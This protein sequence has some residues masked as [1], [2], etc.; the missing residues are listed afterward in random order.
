M[1]HVFVW[2]KDSRLRKQRVESS[3]VAVL[4]ELKELQ[5]AQQ[6]KSRKYMRNIEHKVKEAWGKEADEVRYFRN[7]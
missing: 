7:F 6:D 4:W 1:V 5:R 3:L 2:I